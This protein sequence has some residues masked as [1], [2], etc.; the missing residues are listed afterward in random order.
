MRASDGYG[1]AFER[2]LNARASGFVMRSLPR[3]QLAVTE[4]RYEDPQFIVSTPPAEE[5]AFVVGVHLKLFERYQYWE[6][7]KAAAPSTLRPGEAII[8]HLKRRPTFHLNSA[9]HSVHFCAR[10]LRMRRLRP[11][12][13]FA[14]HRPSVTPTHSFAPTP[15]PCSRCSQPPNEPIASSSTT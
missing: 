3:V 4:L 14:T 11:S 9:F 10:S 2:R 7:G 5:D 15:R 6:N 8:Y 1:E 12:M 13:N